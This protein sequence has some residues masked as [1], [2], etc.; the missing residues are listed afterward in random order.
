[1]AGLGEGM[2]NTS[3]RYG[4]IAAALAWPVAAGAEGCGL[5]LLEA[6]PML[7]DPIGRLVIPFTIEGTKRNVIVDT[8]GYVSLMTTETADASK[9]PKYDLYGTVYSAKGR[10]TTFTKANVDI[11][12]LHASAM[13]F[14]VT[15]SYPGWKERNIV[16][17]LGPEL[18][19]RF[20]VD[21][22]FGGKKLN[23]L[24][25]DHCP[26][27]VVYWAK[28]YS[29]IPFEPDEGGHIELPVILDGKDMKALIDTGATGSFMNYSTARDRFDLEPGGA[30]SVSGEE[31]VARL[32]TMTF[33]SV[34]VQNPRF[35]VAPDKIGQDVQ[36][37][38]AL[39]GVIG[40]KRRAPLIIGN[41]ILR[42][43]HFYI[44][45]NEKKI[46]LTA[47]DAH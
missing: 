15:G 13:Q 32:H 31:F 33:G 20:D 22:D 11:G 4:L 21:F 24:L 43:L 9:L 28:A 19:G 8:G 6:Y 2:L 45:Y 36:S 40:A 10:I 5:K 25:P 1:L 27:Q 44:A 39:S 34:T 23:F 7:E 42:Q 26:G 37:D 30:K 47:A 41:D 46:Y 35:Y 12:P 3:L 29:V 14:L 18:L 16:G 17:A 38:E